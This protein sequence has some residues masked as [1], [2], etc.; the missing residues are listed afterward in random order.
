MKNRNNYLLF[1]SVP[2][3]N[4][5]LKRK[6]CPTVNGKVEYCIMERF[7]G[8]KILFTAEHAQTKRLMMENLG[9]RAYVGVG[10]TNTGILAKI[11]S[12]YMRSAY[13][14]PMFVRTEAD[15][16]R[17]PKELD[18]GLRLFVKPLK[19]KRGAAYLPI[20]KNKNMIT[21]LKNYHSIIEKL[22]PNILISVHGIGSKREF[23]M[24]FGFGE[25]YE[26]IGGKKEAFRFKNEF[27]TYLEKV[28]RD[29]NIRKGLKIGVSTWRFTGSQNFVLNKHVIGYNRKHAK[30]RIGM[31]VEMNFRGRVSTKENP[32]P[33]LQYQIAIQ[34]LGNF[35]YN[36]VN[37]KKDV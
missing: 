36:W 35:V 9:P 4:R 23:D 8:N 25:D 3:L 26:A 29:I 27:I 14:Y 17:P 6:I 22:D 30:K 33:T 2:A 31:Q 34:A 12:Y 28:F 11:G 10:D 37:I 16:S 24:L 21:H 18:R 1:E 32:I 13:I 19:S 20:H 5:F 7:V 15:A